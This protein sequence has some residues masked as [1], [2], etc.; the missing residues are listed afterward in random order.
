MIARAPRFRAAS[1]ASRNGPSSPG[2]R[3]AWQSAKTARIA[4]TIA[5]ID[6]P[7]PA[8][9]YGLHVGQ[10]PAARPARRR[11]AALQ[12]RLYRLLLIPLGLMAANSIYIAA[13]TRD[14]TFFYAMLLLHL[15]LGLLI[16]VPF[17]VFAT[18]HAQRMIRMWNK[19]AKYAGLAIVLLA[20]V[21]VA[22]GVFMTFHG[23]PRSNNRAVW[24]AT[25]APCLPL[26]LV[27]FILHRLCTST[28][29]FEFR[30]LFAWAARS[31]PSSAPW[32][33]WPGSRS[34]RAASPTST[35]TPS[36]IPPR[37]ETFDQ[38]L[39]DGRKPRP[40]PTAGSVT[41]T[42]STSGALG[43]P[44]LVLQQPV[45]PKERRAHGRPRGP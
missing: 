41:R 19:R 40:T 35:A 36:S 38:G 34:R 25:S 45:L 32:P 17:F 12:R 18:T 2:L 15:A 7:A 27:A 4:A 9:E 29:A 26:A 8:L 23:A 16:A 22:T 13:F 10:R 21:C 3:P 31:P 5:E 37:A 30:R 39:L 28:K 1:S 14:S 43:P 24:L 11:L 42:P 20:I 33:S 44:V 6:A